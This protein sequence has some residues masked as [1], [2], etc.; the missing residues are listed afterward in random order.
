MNLAWLS[1]S[2]LFVAI[3]ISCFTRLN[4][5][6]VAVAF[7]WIVGVYFGS[8]PLD[9]VLSGFPIQLFLTLAGESG[10]PV[11][12]VLPNQSPLHNINQGSSAGSMT[13]VAEHPVKKQ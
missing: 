10:T 8:M 7:A 11:T 2:A 5:G 12:F 13:M 6:V 3:I 4:V 9:A 1:L